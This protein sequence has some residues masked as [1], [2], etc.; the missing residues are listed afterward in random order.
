MSKSGLNGLTRSLAVE[1]AAHSVLVNAIA[2][3]FVATE[4]TYRNNSPDAVAAM[5][6]QLPAGRL[7][8]PEE[9]A[10][11]VAFFASARNSFATGQVIVCDGGYSCL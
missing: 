4:M 10:E 5:I 11:I 8:S 7:G 9:I 3:G 6:G 1:L 2:P